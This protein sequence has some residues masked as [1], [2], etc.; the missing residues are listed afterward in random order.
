MQLEDTLRAA[1]Q[2]DAAELVPVGPGP[3]TARRRAFRRKRRIQSGVVML[4]AVGL[5][6]GSIAVIENRP[7]GHGGQVRAQP[8]VQQVT[9][10]L[11][12]RSVD[13]TVLPLG[14]AITGP[15]GVSYLL[16]TAPGTT[17][18]A[19][20]PTDLYSTSDGVKWTDKSIGTQKIGDLTEDGGVL[21]AVATGPGVQGA[22]AYQLSTSSDG[23]AD[24]TP[25]PVPVQ[26]TK[27]ESTLPLLDSERLQ[28]AHRENTTVVIASASYS[29]DTS[30]LTAGHANY[31]TNTTADG[32]AVIDESSCFHDK[33]GAATKAV[34]YQ[35]ESGKRRPSPVFWLRVER[36]QH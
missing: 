33:V 36:L 28:V 35:W 19:N 23:G 2:A 12:W 4:G 15:D 14:A 10:E 7:A 6:G 32:I 21:Y 30:S 8:V 20:A 3:E 16:S 13:G 5:A 11:S 24:W 29:L 9:P 17:G 1:L 27:P 31:F 26:F 22:T 25:T 34:V 18:N